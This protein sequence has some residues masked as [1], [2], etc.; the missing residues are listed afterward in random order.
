MKSRNRRGRAR[1]GIVMSARIIDA[2]EVVNV[3]PHPE[4]PGGILEAELVDGCR[5]SS[6]EELTAW[7]SRADQ[8]LVF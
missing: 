7:T 8:V 3:L 4:L 6:M 5:R 2:T 1:Q